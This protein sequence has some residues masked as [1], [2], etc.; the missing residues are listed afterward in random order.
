[1]PGTNWPSDKYPV[2]FTQGVQ[3]HGLVTRLCLGR[4]PLSINTIGFVAGT[5]CF[6]LFCF[7]IWLQGLVTQTVHM[8]GQV[9]FQGTHLRI[10]PF[11]VNHLESMTLKNGYRYSVA[12]MKGLVTSPCVPNTTDGKFTMLELS[13]QEISFI[14]VCAITVIV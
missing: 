3:L 14:T 13:L 9:Q 10:S 4:G 1:M 5:V 7:F 12:Y 2:V 8:S 11:K 6:V